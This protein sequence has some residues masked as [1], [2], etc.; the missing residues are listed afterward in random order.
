MRPAGAAE[1]GGSVIASCMHAEEARAEAW[2]GLVRGDEGEGDE[3][4]R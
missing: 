4:A 1:A 2:R 3:W